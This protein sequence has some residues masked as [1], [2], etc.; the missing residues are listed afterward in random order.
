MRI[1][2]EDG[3]PDPTLMKKVKSAWSEVRRGV[4]RDAPPL[5][6]KFIGKDADKRLMSHPLES[7]HQAV[8][9]ALSGQRDALICVMQGAALRV[10]ASY[11]HSTR[12]LF[13]GAQIY[14]WCALRVGLVAW[15]EV[16]DVP[17]SGS[18]KTTSNPFLLGDKD[19][20]KY[21]NPEIDSSF[22]RDY[23]TLQSKSGW[24][25]SP[26]GEVS[27]LNRLIEALER[28]VIGLRDSHVNDVGLSEER[29]LELIDFYA[30]MIRMW[31][32][33]P[34]EQPV[35]VPDFSVELPPEFQGFG[36]QVR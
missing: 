32:G 14:R 17:V 7:W 19:L 25:F 16:W 13:Q 5:V 26:E 34:Q 21:L 36:P 27:G 8:V 18:Q 1:A 35:P 15:G 3:G 29:L 24:R 31:M 4:D 30:R 33:L 11:P 28:A 2:R 23:G 22:F 6:L 12:Y 10:A 20:E 9:Y